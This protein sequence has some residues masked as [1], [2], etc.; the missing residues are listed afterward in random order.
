MVRWGYITAVLLALAAWAGAQGP[1]PLPAAER[2]R[3]L[4]AN[5]TLL[6]D[7]VTSG[8]ELGAADGPVSRA[9]ACQKTVHHL[10][11][12]L[13]R[14]ARADDADRVTE[15]GDHLDR[16]LR[17]ALAPVLDEATQTVPPESQDA[18]RLKAVRESAVG[19]LDWARSAI[20]ADGKVGGSAQ[21]RTLADKLDGLRDKLK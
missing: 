2:L 10:S 9:A 21:V 3:L 4:R 13:E 19:D 16:M 15:L 11:I 18:K 14:A 5:R 1:A 7:L 17:D 8:V 20:S 12:A 6:T